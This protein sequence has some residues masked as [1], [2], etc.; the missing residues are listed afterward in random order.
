[1][2]TFAGDREAVATVSRAL[3][4]AFDISEIYDDFT[5]VY[6]A[7]VQVAVAFDDRG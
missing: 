5:L 2:Q 1:M 4:G 7:A 3:D 6:G